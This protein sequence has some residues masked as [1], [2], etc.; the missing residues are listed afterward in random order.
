MR[1]AMEFNFGLAEGL[2]ADA[3]AAAFGLNTLSR[4]E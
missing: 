1:N 4:V 2:L 3:L